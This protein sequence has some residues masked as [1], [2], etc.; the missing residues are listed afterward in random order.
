[1]ITKMENSLGRISRFQLEKSMNLKTEIMQ[2][3]EQMK[4]SE[5]SLRNIWKTM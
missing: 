3:K 5:Q 4:K 1:M 2:S